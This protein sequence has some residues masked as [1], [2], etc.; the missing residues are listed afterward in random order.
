VARKGIFIKTSLETRRHFNEEKIMEKEH[1]IKKIEKIQKEIEKI[2]KEVEYIYCNHSIPGH[3][4]RV[5]LYTR[6]TLR[7]L[8]KIY[9]R[10]RRLINKL[11][12]D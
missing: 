8:G 9:K 5:Y 6:E 7:D 11:E 4:Y 2:F 10:N 3:S 1:I 12:R